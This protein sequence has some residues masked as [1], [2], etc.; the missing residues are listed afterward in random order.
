MVCV[1][2]LVVKYMSD[3]RMFLGL[4][5]SHGISSGVKYVVPHKA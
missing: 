1:A 5:C 4:P 3:K 2:I